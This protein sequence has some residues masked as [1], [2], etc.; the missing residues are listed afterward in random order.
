MR[1]RLT[2]AATLALAVLLSAGGS[3]LVLS[4]RAGM[5]ADLDTAVISEAVH[6][7]A[8]V[9]GTRAPAVGPTPGQALAVQVVDVTGRVA[10]SSSDVE[11]EPPLFRPPSNAERSTPAIWTDRP[12]SLGGEAY[13]V[14][15]VETGQQPRYRVFVGMSLSQVDAST[16]NLAVALL[17]GLP[18]LLAALSG[19]T[20]VLTGRALRPVETMRR[21]AAAIPADRPDRRVDVPAANDELAELASTLN[22][23]LGRLGDAQRQQR[24]FV[25]DAAH[26]LRSPVAAIRAQLETAPLG[27][28][29][30][31]AVVRQGVRLSRL[32]D[33]LLT[34]ARLDA[35]PA[36]ARVEIDLDDVVRAEV[37][38]RA[39]AG[40]VRVDTGRVEPVRVVGDPLLLGRAV[41]NL[42]DNAMRYA[43]S[44]VSVSTGRTDGH[45]LLVVTDDGPGVQEADHERM[46]DRFTRLDDDRGRGSGGVGLGLAIVKETVLAHGGSIRV[47]DAAPGT[48]MVV[49]LPA[50]STDGARG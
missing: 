18:L 10:A 33:D 19:A 12:A 32:V 9:D 25:A 50:S 36:P 24:Q 37:Q 7:A 23:L 26:E 31:A 47:E 39:D 41:A 2:A 27:D 30:R 45:A 49:V 8:T 46:F 35:H 42:L 6:V 20:W 17:I 3:L 34:L 11:G 16:S 13:R 43:S 14:T 21:Q 5:L 38:L 40:T 29:V 15:A 44:T 22:E 48:R 4:V 1:A 28:D